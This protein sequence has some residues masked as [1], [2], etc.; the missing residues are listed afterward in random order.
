MSA[1][2]ESGLEFPVIKGVDTEK[3]INK[4]GGTIIA[5]RQVLSM[6]CKDA[7]ER[8]QLLR[9]FL[10]ESMNAKT[11]PEKHLTSFTTQALALKSAAASLGAG[12]ISQEAGTLEEAG[13]A[14]DLVL[15]QENLSGFIENLTEL[16][17]NIRTAL[18]NLT[19]VFAHKTDGQVPSGAEI[20]NPLLIKLAG[21][22]QSKNIADID[23]SIEELRKNAA[24]KR[25]NEILEHISDQVLMT[26]FESA[27]NTLDDL[28]NNKEFS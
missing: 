19:G 15:I 10:F 20:N 8:L 28:I 1:K 23:S 21:A 13:K 5:Y 6:F 18:E 11:F 2:D 25:T 4:T 27:V 17:A 16:V 9:F 7:K 24:D 26:E 12:K 22:L 14:G 3:G